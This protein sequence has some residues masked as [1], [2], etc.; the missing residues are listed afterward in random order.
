MEFW[1]TVS[2]DNYLYLKVVR[3]RN[4]GILV[5]NDNCLYLKGDLEYGNLGYSYQMTNLYLRVDLEYGILGYWYQM[6]IIYT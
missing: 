4:F 1:D 2:N 3:I 6:T 5:S